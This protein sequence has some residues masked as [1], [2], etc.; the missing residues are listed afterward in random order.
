MVCQFNRYYLN[1]KV[2]EAET[3]GKRLDDEHAISQTNE[4]ITQNLLSLHTYGTN[5]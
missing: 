5:N 1:I 4:I 3:Q 2:L